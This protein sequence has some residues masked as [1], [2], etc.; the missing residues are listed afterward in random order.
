MGVSKIQGSLNTD[1]EV[2]GLLTRAPTKR[3][4]NVICDKLLVVEYSEEV[5]QVS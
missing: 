4:P 3:T 5:A 1:P 2:V